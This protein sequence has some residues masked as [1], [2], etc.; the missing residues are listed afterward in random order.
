MLDPTNGQHPYSSISLQLQSEHKFV[1]S[2]SLQHFVIG[3]GPVL[4]SLKADL[5]AS[6]V[7]MCTIQCTWTPMNRLP[8]L[9]RENR[10]NRTDGTD[11][12]ASSL[13]RMLNSIHQSCSSQDGHAAPNTS[14]E[15]CPLSPKATVALLPLPLEKPSWCNQPAPQPRMRSYCAWA[16]MSLSLS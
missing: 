16:A 2:G 13:E 10:T 11:L 9:H 4:S 14:T 5:S 15:H 3:Q 8:D 7:S 1:L 12:E 6:T